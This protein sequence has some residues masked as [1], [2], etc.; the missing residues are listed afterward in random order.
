M[1]MPFDHA[2]GAVICGLILTV[3]IYFVVRALVVGGG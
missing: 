2:V 3:L 1:K